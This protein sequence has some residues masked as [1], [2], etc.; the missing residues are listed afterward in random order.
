MP[1]KKGNSRIALKQKVNVS[2]KRRTP[3]EKVTVRIPKP[4]PKAPRK[5]TEG[6][7]AKANP[8]VESK[9]QATAG[10][11]AAATLIAAPS[12]SMPLRMPNEG[13]VRLGTMPEMEK[14]AGTLPFFVN[15]TFDANNAYAFLVVYPAYYSPIWTITSLGNAGQLTGPVSVG[16]PGQYAGMVANAAVLRPNAVGASFKLWQ[17]N[18][19][20]GGLVYYQVLQA[21][22][23]SGSFTAGWPASV[24]AAASMPGIHSMPLTS[25]R[26]Q[27]WVP[28]TEFLSQNDFNYPSLSGATNHPVGMMFLIKVPITSTVTP[29]NVDYSVTL[30]YEMVPLATTQGLF[31]TKATV[32]TADAMEDVNAAIADKTGG[33]SN[34]APTPGIIDKVVGVG[35]EILGVGKK[36]WDVGKQVWDFAKPFASAIGGLFGFLSP[37]KESQ[38]LNAWIIYQKECLAFHQDMPLLFDADFYMSAP[39]F[40]AH[41]LTDY[42]REKIVRNERYV[43]HHMAVLSHCLKSFSPFAVH[44]LASRHGDIP[45]PTYAFPENDTGDFKI[46]NSVIMADVAVVGSVGPAADG[47]LP[48]VCISPFAYITTGPPSQL[49]FYSAGAEYSATVVNVSV[50]K[51]LHALPPP[52]GVPTQVRLSLAKCY[53]LDGKSDDDSGELTDT[54]STFTPVELVRQNRPSVPLRPTSSVRSSSESATRPVPSTNALWSDVGHP[55][56]HTATITRS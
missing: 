25:C 2:S 29:G 42:H 21:L 33:S 54:E 47:F 3:T 15:P 18:D 5:R 22:D 53:D 52:V 14:M 7:K 32:I 38:M 27:E 9:S 11:V 28:P 44:H 24:T 36:A 20:K 31:D 19:A 30:Q 39:A 51:L 41:G 55:K 17:I 46:S 4:A 34:Q 16:T 10:A 6:P 45:I 8:L 35:K 49:L 37:E 43:N 50:Q 48:I 13:N 23:S 40:F 26:E 1:I 12:K 56:T